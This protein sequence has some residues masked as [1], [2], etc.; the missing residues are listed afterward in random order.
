MC[1][2][3][4]CTNNISLLTRLYI[5]LKENA[6][7][8]GGHPHFSF[9]G[10]FDPNLGGQGVGVECLPLYFSHNKRGEYVCLGVDVPGA[11]MWALV[12]CHVCVL[13]VGDVV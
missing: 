7:C 4:Y 9:L 5:T 6:L 3:F 2:T 1:L 8:V 13:C 12:W 10:L 11:G